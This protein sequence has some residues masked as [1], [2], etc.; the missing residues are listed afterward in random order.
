LRSPAPELRRIVS[1]EIIKPQIDTLR[2]LF[3]RHPCQGLSTVLTDPRIEHVFGD[4]RLVLKVD[5][6]KFDIIEADALRPQNAY[7]GISIRVNTSPCC[8]SN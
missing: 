8:A 1:I 2:A 3:A 6:E 7:A 4:G 5:R